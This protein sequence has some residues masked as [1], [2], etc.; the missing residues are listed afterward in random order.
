MDIYEL[1]DVLTG[2]ELTHSNG[3]DLITHILTVLFGSN[4]PYCTNIFS[5]PSYLL[6]QDAVQESPRSG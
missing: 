5:F 2:R 6:G 4:L 1:A 3:P